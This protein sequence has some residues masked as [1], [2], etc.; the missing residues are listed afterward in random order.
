[1]VE[2]ALV[3]YARGFTIVYVQN[4]LFVGCSKLVTF[5]S[6]FLLEL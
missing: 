1:M 5:E 2:T 6:T 3:G 4:L